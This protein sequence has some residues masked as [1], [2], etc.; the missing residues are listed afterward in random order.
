[1]SEDFHNFYNGINKYNLSNIYSII[2]GYKRLDKNKNQTMI[3]LEDYG[4]KNL[5]EY[6]VEI[7]ETIL[8]S[9]IILV[10]VIKEDFY[11]DTSYID[12]SYFSFKYI[13]DK[14]NIV[15]IYLI[16][17]SILLILIIICIIVCE[18]RRRRRKNNDL[19]EKIVSN[20]LQPIE[21]SD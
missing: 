12:N 20:D 15:Y 10:P 4:G 5:I 18:I 14:S 13:D 7:N 16:V 6:R 3:I 21:A 1:M 11:I 19:S 9:Y 8:D 17:M 2:G